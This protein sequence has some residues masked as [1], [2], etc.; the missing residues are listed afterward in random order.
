LFRPGLARVWLSV[1]ESVFDPCEE[2]HVRAFYSSR[3]GN[4]VET[5]GPTG[6]PKVVKIL[7][8]I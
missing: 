6:G 2:A 5:Q 3:L 4:Y 8:S 7:Y 1:R